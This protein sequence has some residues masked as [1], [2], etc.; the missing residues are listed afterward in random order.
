MIEAEIA[1][2]DS[3]LNLLNKRRLQSGGVDLGDQGH[4][5]Q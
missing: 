3:A 1:R 4:S 5:D 2:R